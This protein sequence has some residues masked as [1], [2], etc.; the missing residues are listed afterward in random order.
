MNRFSNCR[1]ARGRRRENS[2]R[3]ST[4]VLVLLCCCCCCYSE[5][6]IAYRLAC[7][8]PNMT[9]LPTLRPMIAVT[10]AT[11][12][13]LTL[14]SSIDCDPS[15]FL[16]DCWHRPTGRTLTDYAGKNVWII[17]ASSGIGQE[18]A[19]QLTRAGCANLILSSRNEPR[20]QAVGFQCREES[21]DSTFQCHCRPLD[22]FAAD[23]ESLESRLADVV[24]N[25]L[26]VPV[27]IVILNAGSGQLQPALETSASMVQKVMNV[28]A[29]WPMLLVPLLF[30]H[31][32][33]R[34]TAQGGTGVPHLM[35]T[36]SIAALLPVPLSAVYAAAKAAQRQYFCSLAA[37][38]SAG[39]IRIDMI[40]PGPVE[41]GFHRNH[42]EEGGGKADPSP[43]TASTMSLE[44]GKEGSSTNTKSRTKMSVRRSVHL[45]LSAMARE[46]KDAYTEVWIAPPP[47][48]TILYLQ[49]VFP[50]LLQRITSK[51]GQ[52][53]V[54]LWK[55]GK[56]LYDPKSWR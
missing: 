23:A 18:L 27:D 26:P 4:K 12:G 45:M 44:D 43:T 21:R 11:L 56:D 35:V 8:H 40:C 30:Q 39:A 37:E 54:E 22:V 25:Q 10:A 6:V 48:I 17:G 46:S 53:R 20:L 2:R 3:I 42:L 32:I 31:G 52:K 14:T 50:S 1:G 13:S 5:S 49:R 55:S 29:L 36:N 51:F 9:V 47:F 15:L 19:L 33:F 28:N 16:W 38:Q 24:R 41:T 7:A 34:S